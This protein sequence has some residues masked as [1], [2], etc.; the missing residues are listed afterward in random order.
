M[1]YV[2]GMGVEKRSAIGGEELRGDLGGMFRS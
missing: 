1:R 2:G